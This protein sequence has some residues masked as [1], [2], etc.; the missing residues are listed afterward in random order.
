MRIL[1]ILDHS[2]PLHSGYTFRSRAILREQNALGWETFH[3]TGP[4]HTLSV[5]DAPPKERVD[6]I[7]F[8]RTKPGQGI[9]ASLPVVNQLSVI[10]ALMQRMQEVI[11]LVKPDILHA[12]S[13]ALNGVATIAAGKKNNIPT[14]YEVRGFWED[15]AISHGTTQK[16]SLR[17]HLTRGIETWVLKHSDAVTCICEGIKNDLLARG[18]TEDRITIIPNAVDSRR[19]MPNTQRDPELESTLGL[20]NKPVVGFIGSFYAYEGLK[21]ILDAMPAILKYNPDVRALLVGGGQETNNLKEKAKAMGIDRQILFTGRV[22]HD[23]VER[24]YSLIDILCYPRIP[25]RLTELVTPLKPLE[26][27]AQKKLVIASDVGGHHELIQNG[28]TGVLF[29]A[30]DA[31]DLASK[32]LFLYKNRKYWSKILESGRKFV[33]HERTWV[34]SVARYS[35]VYES[36]CTSEKK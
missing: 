26:A 8:Y 9:M 21:L 28:C 13:P 30:G 12:H 18:I 19:F 14:V 17:Y 24:Y 29:K 5:R 22:P 3:L 4:K 25:M 20:S 27:M 33:E 35:P 16:N 36:L 1:H 10:H 32:I 11:R 23:Q 31:D 7:L 2:L 6:D 34:R 15:A